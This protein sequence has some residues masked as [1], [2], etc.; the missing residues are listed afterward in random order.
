MPRRSA[1]IYNHEVVSGTSTFDIREREPW[2]SSGLWLSERSGAHTVVLVAEI[3]GAVVGFGSLS[4]YKDRDRPTTALGRELGVRGSPGIKAR[5]SGSGEPCSRRSSSEGH[6]TTGSTLLIAQDRSRVRGVSINGPFAKAGWVE[7]GREREVGR[8]FGRWLDI[9][10][11][12]KHARVS[13]VSGTTSERCSSTTL[14]EA[15]SSGYGARSPRRW[16][17]ATVTP[18]AFDELVR[19]TYGDVFKL[20]VRLTGNETDA[21]DVV[22]DTYVRAFRGLRRFRGRC[23]VLHLALPDRVELR[24]IRSRRGGHSQR[25]DSL[26]EAEGVAETDPDQDPTLRAEASTLRLAVE[27]ALEQ[28][29][30]RL[31]AVVVLKHLEDLSHR[32]IAERLGITEA[33][34][35]VRLHR[36]R[37][38]LRRLLPHSDDDGDIAEVLHLDEHRVEDG[39]AQRASGE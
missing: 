20:A 5:G 10:I 15:V 28:L 38:T 37:H 7:I 32:E 33:A 21:N 13:R 35:K 26:S 29:P 4:K 24:V 2:P 19:R 8:K 27:R 39:P 18:T 9:V 14:S 22:Q 17:R 6:A 12:Q 23:P 36:A 34:T 25:C 31:R 16:L 11:M 3:D 30:Q 1:S